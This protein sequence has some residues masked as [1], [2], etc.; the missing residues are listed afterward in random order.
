[1]N[2]CQQCNNALQANLGFCPHCG[3]SVMTQAA[4]QPR[5]QAPF[6]TT[7]TA[8]APLP[9]NYNS[10]HGK[11]A[12]G[13]AQMFGLHPTIAMLTILVDLMVFGGTFVTAG[14]G[15]P[16]LA[17]AAAGLGYVTYKGQVNWFGDDADSA[18]IKA[19]IIAVLTA[20]PVPIASALAVFMGITGK[21]RRG[22]NVPEVM[23]IQNQ[24]AQ[25]IACR[26]CNNA[27][28]AGGQFCN[29]CGAALYGMPQTAHQHGSVDEF[30][31]RT[32][33]RGQG[34]R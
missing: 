13:F 11:M 34:G 30:D 25:M 24:P 29:Y 9:P 3:A 6:P 31:I 12:S 7:T 4:M 8:S 27:N 32:Q 5:Q 21:F 1:M 10:Y 16:V 33:L 2:R 15:W 22:K 17:M 14:I 18:K 20:I 23:P 26:N 28:L 19:V